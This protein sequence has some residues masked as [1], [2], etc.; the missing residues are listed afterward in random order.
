MLNE[1]VFNH[2][3]VSVAG[4]A[5]DAF[6]RKECNDKPVI[7]FIHGYL[8]NAASF[9]YILPYLE[10]YPCVALDLAGHGLSQHRSF[11][12][13]YHLVDY[14]YDLHRFILNEGFSRVVLVG[15]SLGAIVSSIYAATQTKTLIG[16]IAIESIG[17]LSQS[18]STTAEQIRDSFMS[19]DN[20]SKPIK[21]PASL[22][23]LVKARCA[24][25]DLKPK[26]A[27]LILRRNVQ[28]NSVGE[29][30]WRTDKRLRTQ[31]C[32]RMTE[33]QASNVLENIKCA[34]T[35]IIGSHGFEKIKRILQKRETLFSKVETITI[36][37]GHHVHLDSPQEV[38]HFINKSVISFE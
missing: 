18:P 36:S 22:E 17:P 16:F 3:A 4:L 23:R 34:R 20:A 37:G 7:I 2:S 8:D 15:H 12:A 30:E 33:E 32:M 28:E 9:S 1:V 13:H 31:S 11:D 26:D 21:Q 24:I 25:S 6:V 5:N 19:R 10:D 29:L 38:A 14:A 27:A 35:L